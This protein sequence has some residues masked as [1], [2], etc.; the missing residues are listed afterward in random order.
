MAS[1]RE[2]HPDFD[3]FLFDDQSAEKFLS[4]HG[5]KDVLLAYQ[6]AH[7]PAQQCD[8]FRLAYLSVFGGIYADADDRCLD[9]VGCFV[10]PDARFVAFQEDFGTLGNNFLAVAP[11]HPVINLA[12]QL[13]VTA[14]N[15]GDT[16]MLWLST[17]PG[18]LTRAFAQ[19]LASRETQLEDLGA[20]ILDMGFTMRHIG[21]RCPA[22]YK[23][24]TQYWSR[25]L[26]KTE[27]AVRHAA[28]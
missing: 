1:W 19:L 17:G 18:L 15:R 27:K 11:E 24:T 2:Q 13:G 10:P 9:A 16:D 12:L 21:L 7:E 14:I 28:N 4:D 8:I 5:M 20:V 22:R 23:T 3:Y 25:S 6:R 26:F